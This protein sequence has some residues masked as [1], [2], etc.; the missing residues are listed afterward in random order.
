MSDSGSLDLGR[1]ELHLADDG[2]FLH[3]SGEA[4]FTG[5]ENNPNGDE[6][7]GVAHLRDKL[8]DQ[9]ETRRPWVVKGHDYKLTIDLELA[10][11]LEPE[12]PEFAQVFAVK[13]KQS[14]A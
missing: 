9:D 10:A 3:L 5:F 6:G 7:A 1:L 13:M 8:L 2:L 4:E 11:D 14:E 12:D